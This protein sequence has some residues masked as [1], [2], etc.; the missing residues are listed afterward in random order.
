M[1]Y[2][3]KLGITYHHLEIHHVHLSSQIHN[4]YQKASHI[5][6]HLGHHHGARLCLHHGLRPCLPCNL[7]YCYI[8]HLVSHHIR[9]SVHLYYLCNLPRVY[10]VLSAAAADNLNN[11]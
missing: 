3:V 8:L 11:E 10:L 9:Y 7:P 2:C 1:K 6:L 4:R 5:C